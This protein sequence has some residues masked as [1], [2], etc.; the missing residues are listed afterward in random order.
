MGAEY[1][2]SWTKAKLTPAGKVFLEGR[3]VN[4]CQLY[5]HTKE[6]KVDTSHQRQA[7]LTLRNFA[8]RNTS[9]PA[10]LLNDSRSDSVGLHMP[11]V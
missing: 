3:L 2:V 4:E 10:E 6:S 9:Q 8:A 1:S 7:M 11:A 5:P